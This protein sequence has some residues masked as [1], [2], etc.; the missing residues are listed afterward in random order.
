MTETKLRVN[1]IDPA[2]I[3]SKYIAHTWRQLQEQLGNHRMNEKWHVEQN[4]RNV[5]VL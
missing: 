4:S 1:Q 2:S 3:L 5:E